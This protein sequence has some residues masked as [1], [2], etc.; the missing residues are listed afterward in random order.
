MVKVECRRYAVLA[1]VNRIGRLV[2]KYATDKEES[3][4]EALR[5]TVAMSWSSSVDPAHNLGKAKLLE[6]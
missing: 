6:G 3:V 4:K 2:F 1:Q 5:L